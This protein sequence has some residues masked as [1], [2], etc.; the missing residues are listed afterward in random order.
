M[1]NSLISF[2]KKIPGS[3]FILKLYKKLKF[4]IYYPLIKGKEALFTDYYERRIWGNPESVSGA[5][6]TISYTKTLRKELPEII[7]NLEVDTLLDAP[8]GDFNWF[9][10]IRKELD[11]H[12]IGGDIVKELITENQQTYKFENTRF[13]HLDITKEELPNADIWLCRDCLIH[14]SDYDIKKAFSR[15]IDSDIPYL[16]TT[17]HPLNTINTNIATG[18]VRLLNLEIEP[19]NFPKPLIV[20]DDWIEGYPE[21]KLGLWKREMIEDQIQKLVSK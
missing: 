18:E 21:K 15:F 2:F 7:N 5:G 12:Y 20:I 8:C 11:I 1:G 13:I 17:T 6:S 16:L 14:F 3:D 4:N 19:F 9:K 10:E